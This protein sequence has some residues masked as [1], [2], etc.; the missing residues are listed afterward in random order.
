MVRYR[1]FQLRYDDGNF[2]DD[3]RPAEDTICHQLFLTD[4]G[5]QE[6]TELAEREGCNFSPA[7]IKAAVKRLKLELDDTQAR[8]FVQRLRWMARFGGAKAVRSIHLTCLETDDDPKRGQALFEMIAACV[9]K[10]SARSL[11]RSSHS[12]SFVAHC[13]SRSAR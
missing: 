1:T 6:A 12:A 13:F 9:K 10:A 2:A 3:P 4:A 11:Q 5:R 7:S 8:T